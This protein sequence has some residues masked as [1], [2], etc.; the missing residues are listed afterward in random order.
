MEMTVAAF[1]A[2]TSP[3]KVGTREMTLHAGAITWGN[4]PAYLMDGSNAATLRPDIA[5]L[6]RAFANA[7]SLSPSGSTYY[8]AP[9]AWF[10]NELKLRGA[11]AQ[12]PK[13]QADR[14][15]NFV[16]F[17][18]DGLASDYKPDS[19][20]KDHPFSKDYSTFLEYAG[21]RGEEFCHERG[22][23]DNN[24][25]TSQNVCVNK[26][27]VNAS[28][29]ASA[30]VIRAVKDIPGTKVIGKY[31]FFLFRPQ[32][33]ITCMFSKLTLFHFACFLLFLVHV[34]Q[35]STLGTE[36]GLLVQPYCTIFLVVTT[37]TLIL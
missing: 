10:A 28:T 16:I 27:G 30:N 17:L 24:T 6:E 37:M 9:F 34:F 29:C 35:V 8:G 26:L 31:I 15:Q 25:N 20:G 22:W 33:S 18:T 5:S 7:T 11:A 19:D 32:Q 13:Y 3:A 36:Q 2:A 14:Q 23:C 21:D 12:Q 4:T 1:K